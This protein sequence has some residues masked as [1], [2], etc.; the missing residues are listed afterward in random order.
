MPPGLPIQNRWRLA[1]RRQFLAA[2]SG[3]AI[4]AIGIA[5][6]FA[7]GGHAGQQFYDPDRPP[8]MH[9]RKEAYIAPREAVR[10]LDDGGLD[11]RRLAGDTGALEA[12]LRV[13]GADHVDR[14]ARQIVFVEHRSGDART[15]G[16]AAVV[17]LPVGDVVQR[18]RQLDDER[19]RGS[20]AGEALRHFLDAR[21][22]PP[23]VAGALPGEPFA[24]FAGDTD[25]DSL[26]IH[27]EASV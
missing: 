27:T 5:R 4:G 22:V 8:V 1:G 23:I 14:L 2:V 20:A 10:I 25:D 24:Y 26:L 17:K 12:D 19:V 3:D 16:L 7:Y 9:T 11:R 15:H 13:G 6:A 21:R 18:R